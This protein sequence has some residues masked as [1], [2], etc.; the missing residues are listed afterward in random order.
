MKQLRSYHAGLVKDN[1][2]IAHLYEVDIYER[3]MLFSRFLHVFLFEASSQQEHLSV[4]LL[5]PQALPY[6][7]YFY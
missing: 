6:L 7:Q 5:L 1:N 3:I 2:G 4:F